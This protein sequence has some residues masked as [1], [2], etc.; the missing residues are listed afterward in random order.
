GVAF[1]GGAID[2]AATAVRRAALRARRPRV[3]LAAG[4]GLETAR[5]RAIRLDA[6]TAARLGAGAGAGVE[7]GNPPGAP[8]RPWGAGLPPGDGARAEV[9]PD[10]LRILALPDGAEVE[11]R[12]VHG[13]ALSA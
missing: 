12:A 10:A 9:A 2:P 3:R 11:I 13:G 6:G 5:G 4:S 8:L 1:A 7:L